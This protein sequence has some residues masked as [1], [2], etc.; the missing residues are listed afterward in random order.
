MDP[1]NAFLKR[2]KHLSTI[3]KPPNLGFPVNFLGCLVKL[4]QPMAKTIKEAVDTPQLHEGISMTWTSFFEHITGWLQWNFSKI[5]TPRVDFS[6]S[7]IE[8][9]PQ[10][11]FSTATCDDANYLYQLEKQHWFPCHDKGTQKATPFPTR[12]MS[13]QKRPCTFFFGTFFFGIS[14]CVN[15]DTMDMAWLT[16]KIL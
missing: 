4:F 7:E 6:S 12:K 3:Y 9:P 11:T 2:K 14:S 15:I 1:E 8:K 16:Q 13:H 5:D 10:N